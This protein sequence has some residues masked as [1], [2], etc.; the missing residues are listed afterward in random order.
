MKHYLIE[1]E[2]ELLGGR[3]IM[4]PLW[5]EVNGLAYLFHYHEYNYPV[6]KI[7]GVPVELVTL[8]CYCRV[9]FQDGP[10]HSLSGV[11]SLWNDII[12]KLHFHEQEFIN[13]MEVTVLPVMICQNCGTSD[14]LCRY[15]ACMLCDAALCRTCY[16]AQQYCMAHL[17]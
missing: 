1:D 12:G 8:T 15:E 16:S 3:D 17:C 14:I 4:Q 13:L 2:K 7:E 10:P 5:P 6:H 9:V 11:D